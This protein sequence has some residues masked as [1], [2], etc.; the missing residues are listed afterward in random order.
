MKWIKINESIKTNERMSRELFDELWNRIDDKFYKYS[1][2]GQGIPFGLKDSIKDTMLR[3]VDD[4]VTLKGS[5]ET[6]ID[7]ND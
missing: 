7:N 3:F 4:G 1:K 5:N 6:L 2:R